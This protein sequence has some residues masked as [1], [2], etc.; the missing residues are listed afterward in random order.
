MKAVF[1]YLSLTIMGFSALVFA[2]EPKVEMPETSEM[3]FEDQTIFKDVA[4]MLR[5]PTCTGLS[6][7]DSDAKFSLQIQN[8]VKEQIDQGKSKDQILDF[9]E[10]RYGPWIL[11]EPPKKGFN[12]VAWIFPLLLII[13]GPILVWMLVW[14]RSRDTSE[15]TVRSAEEIAE[16]FERAVKLTLSNNERA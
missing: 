7:L 9:F 2:E 13:L 6:V 1:F 10:N 3:S 12:I 5:C 15:N 8:V 14:R 16:E 4:G 11:R